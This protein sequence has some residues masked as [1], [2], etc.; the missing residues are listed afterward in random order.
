[1]KRNEIN[2]FKRMFEQLGDETVQFLLHFA[3]ETI[4]HIAPSSPNFYFC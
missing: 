3:D 1:M 4:N 2:R